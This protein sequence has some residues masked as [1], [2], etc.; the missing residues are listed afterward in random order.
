MRNIFTV[1]Y[2][3]VLIF[4]ASLSHAQDKTEVYQ[5]RTEVTDAWRT[6]SDLSS[7]LEEDLSQKMPSV[8]G[9]FCTPDMTLPSSMSGAIEAIPTLSLVCEHVEQEMR[10]TFFLDPTSARLQCEAIENKK[11]GIANGRVKSDAFRFFE[12]GDWHIMRSGVDIQG[13][14]SGIL[15]FV[16]KGDR[17][18]AAID[19]GLSAIDQFG[20]AMLAFD[21]AEIFGSETFAEQQSALIRFVDGLEIQAHYLARMIPLPTDSPLDIVKSAP[22]SERTPWDLPMPSILTSAP[23]ASATLELKD[24]RV[25]VELSASEVMI[26]EAMRTSGRWASPGGT[27]G[28]VKNVYMRRNTERFVGRERIDGTGIEAFVDNRVIVRVVIPGAPP[29]E[30]APD[31]VARLFREIITNDL[32]T[33]GIR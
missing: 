20:E 24:C 6:A 19:M 7:R 16:A 21:A 27:D 3:I 30:S 18:Q 4:S 28:E 29:C 25:I 26:E 17:S 23:S 32:S 13:C 2:N 15:A 9:W 10:V 22:S 14:S 1:V 12:A 5:L 31:I 33:F 11:S 8:S